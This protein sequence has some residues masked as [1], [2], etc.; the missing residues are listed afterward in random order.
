[1]NEETLKKIHIWCSGHPNEDCQ[2]CL[3][4]RPC[5]EMY[6]RKDEKRKETLSDEK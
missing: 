1:M 3:Y 2:G 5:L 4:L 6:K